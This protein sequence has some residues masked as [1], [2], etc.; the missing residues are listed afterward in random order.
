MAKL[1]SRP[2]V[3]LEVVKKICEKESLSANTKARFSF[4]DFVRD[5]TLRKTS[6]YNMAIWFAWSL[7]YYGISFNI[8][9][10]KGDI[11][12]NVFLMG[13]VNALGQRAA[14]LINDSMGRRK[15]LFASMS[16]CALFLVILAICEI[17]LDHEDI[18]IAVLSLCL[19]GQFGMASA[20]SAA[21]LLSGESFPT[22]VRTMGMGIG[23]ITANI[24]G[25]MTPQLAY[26]GSSKFISHNY[27]H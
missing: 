9:N 2:P 26:L 27:H 23:G 18:P 11:Y 20:R 4:L 8:K 7:T 17:I 22:A 3:G 13:L 6:I 1:N 25:I 12:F 24:A 19:L 21:R 15:A 10:V 5:K 14:L 16:F